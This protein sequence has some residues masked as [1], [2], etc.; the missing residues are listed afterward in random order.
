MT[1]LQ[2]AIGVAQ[3]DKLEDF[4]QRR[5]ENFAYLKE[6]LSVFADKLL[7]PDCL[8]GSDPAWFGFPITIMI[9]FVLLFF[10][11]RSIG[12]AFAELVKNSIE[13]L[14]VVLGVI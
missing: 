10:A 14:E 6:K 12:G 11:T 13:N 4:N 1:D 2:A 8:P 5:R 3:F 7:L 9:A